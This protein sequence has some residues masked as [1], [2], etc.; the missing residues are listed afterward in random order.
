ME[1]GEGKIISIC[2]SRMGNEIVNKAK[3]ERD[4][5]VIIQDNLFPERQI[6]NITGET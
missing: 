5:Q 4:L 3:K 2:N 1:V 6:N